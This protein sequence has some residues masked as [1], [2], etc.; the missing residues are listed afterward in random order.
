MQQS[1][2]NGQIAVSN[3][4]Y[5]VTTGG[6]GDAENVVNTFWSAVGTEWLACANEE[7]VIEQREAINIETPTDF[8]QLT[9]DVAC[10]RTGGEIPSGLTAIARS[11]KD[12]P[13]D[14]YSYRRFMFGSNAD[15]D[16]AVDGNWGSSFRSDFTDLVNK[17][18]NVIVV[19][20]G[21]NLSPV[22]LQAGWRLGFAPTV[23]KHL[24]NFW[25]MAFQP[26]WLNSREE[27]YT[28]Y[29]ATN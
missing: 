25:D 14:R 24:T 13:G 16:D 17:L 9:A 23:N 2:P 28:Y 26:G 18:N 11:S 7:C 5:Q 29:S 1:H 3:F 12:F 8:F 10:L 20:G 21:D 27:G 22:Q 4:F 19:T 6:S 15:L